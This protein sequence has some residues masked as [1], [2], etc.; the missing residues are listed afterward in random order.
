MMSVNGLTVDKSIHAPASATVPAS[1]SNDPTNQRVV[2]SKSRDTPSAPAAAV[3]R[4][5][6]PGLAC[7]SSL[8]ADV[9]RAVS[10]I[11]VSATADKG[12]DRHLT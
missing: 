1:S 6:M 12:H 4:T 9:A 11:R 5:T 3:S 7:S 2:I 10:G 8:P